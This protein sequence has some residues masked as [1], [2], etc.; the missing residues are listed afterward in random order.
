MEL[1]ACLAEVPRGLN[2]SLNVLRGCAF[3]NRLVVFII[4]SAHSIA[5]APGGE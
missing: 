5:A 1:Y 4:K 3:I 2:V